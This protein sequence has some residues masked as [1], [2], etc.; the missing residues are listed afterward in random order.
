VAT[1]VGLAVALAATRSR[2]AFAADKPRVSIAVVGCD[3]GLARE[4]Q[5]IATVE[6]RAT[7][8]ESPPDAATTRVSATCDG[9]LAELKVLDPTTGKSVERRVALAQAAPT[10]RAR[11]LALAI[12]ELVAASWSELES[13]PR[14]AAPPA[15]PLAPFISREAARAAIARPFVELAAV[16]DTHVLASNDWLFGGGARAS[17]WI[18]PVFLVRLD[19]LAD[20]AELSR[21]AGTVAVTMPSLSAAF[22]ASFTKGVLRPAITLG[23]RAGYVWMNGVADN[24]GNVGSRE[25]GTWFGPE[26]ALE[27]GV[28]PRARV[29]PVLALSAGAHVVGVKGT[30]SEG[31]DVEATAIWG[32]LSLGLAVR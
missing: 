7:L 22:G 21:G 31:R 29:H 1:A 24:A 2:G 27:L 16:A 18:S 20:Y 14:P 25:R 26:A 9:A 4:A 23:A 32:G 11:L 5:R 13:N 17:F 8:V 6:L 10:A 15:E 28:W 19:V 3:D 30:V 12:A